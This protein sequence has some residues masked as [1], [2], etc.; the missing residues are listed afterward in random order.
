[1]FVEV[2]TKAYTTALIV[3]CFLFIGSTAK[4]CKETQ[5]QEWFQQIGT[6]YQQV[7][8]RDIERFGL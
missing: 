3:G 5:C 8:Q 4:T 2:V 7:F 1:M 6:E